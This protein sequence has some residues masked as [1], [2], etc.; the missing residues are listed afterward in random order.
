MAEHI[1]ATLVFHYV[2]S[3]L[4]QSDYQV[5]RN[6]IAL[7]TIALVPVDVMHVTALGC[8]ITYKIASASPE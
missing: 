3:E 4:K 1:A 2:N 6:R 5:Q 8:H 7:E